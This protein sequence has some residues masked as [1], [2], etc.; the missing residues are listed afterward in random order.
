MSLVIESDEKQREM[1]VRADISA[2]GQILFNLVD[3]ACKYCASAK[4]RRTHLETDKKGAFV[5]MRLRDHG[6]GISRKDA[7]RIFRPFC[8]S[9][10]E[11]V[12]PSFV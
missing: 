7:S 3:N 10:R 6:P 5:E 11:A 8:K 9:A 2:V 1:R 4:D 12:V